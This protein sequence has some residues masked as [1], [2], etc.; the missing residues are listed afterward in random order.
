MSV[1]FTKSGAS[2]IA[3]TARSMAS[4]ACREMLAATA[5]LPIPKPSIL[6][7]QME[8][9]DQASIASAVD[10]VRAEFGHLDIMIINAG[11][12]T[13]GYEMS[14]LGVLRLT[15]FLAAE[16]GDDGLVVYSI[17]PGDVP[18]DMVGGPEEVDPEIKHGE[19]SMHCGS[20]QT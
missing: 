16:L 15:E 1:S 5:D 7:I 17:H 19:L 14:K 4:E 12:L 11:V 6:P 2:K 10:V 8:V 9:T 3:I 13:K 18:T 20:T